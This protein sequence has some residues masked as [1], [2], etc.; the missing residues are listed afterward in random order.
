MGPNTVIGPTVLHSAPI[1]L[2]EGV[3]FHS[4]DDG[5]SDDEKS[6]VSQDVH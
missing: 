3:S 5:E 6:S 2:E 1:I 4:P